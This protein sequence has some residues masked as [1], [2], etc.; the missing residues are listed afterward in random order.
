MGYI[1]ASHVRGKI[2]L[3]DY[4]ALSSLAEST[5]LICLTE[6]D[7]AILLSLLQP[8]AWRRRYFSSSGA[9]IDVAVIESWQISIQERLMAD[10]C[11][12]IIEKLD[13]LTEKVDTANTKLD[14]VLTEITEFRADETT[15]DI[16]KDAALLAIA[17]ELTTL[18]AAVALDSAAI[19]GIALLLSS[20]S[21]EVHDVHIV[22]DEILAA[23]EEIDCSA[24]IYNLSIITNFNDN[25]MIEIVLAALAAQS[26][27]L[28]AK[29]WLDKED[30]LSDTS[31]FAAYCALVTESTR[32]IRSALYRFIYFLDPAE[33]AL[34]ALYTALVDAGGY[35]TGSVFDSAGIPSPPTQADAVA[36]AQ[37]DTAIATVACDLALALATRSLAFA[38]W[39]DA[40]FSLTGYTA[41]SNEELIANLLI[42][43]ATLDILQANYAGFISEYP[44]MYEKAYAAAPTS[45]QDCGCG[46]S[47]C[48]ASATDF[49]VGEKL[50]WI[51][52]RGIY[53]QG[54]GLTATLLNGD[55]ANYGIDISIRNPDLTCQIDSITVTG[56]IQGGGAGGNRAWIEWWH[57]VDGIEV[58]YAE[59]GLSSTGSEQTWDENNPT[60]TTYVSRVRFRTNSTIYGTSAQT[61]TWAIFQSAT[62]TPN[63]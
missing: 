25:L 10:L 4:D 24:P 54:V 1:K 33:S 63:I 38:S 31:A 29:T 16:L 53:R 39:Q 50:P 52:N 60:P 18:S 59:S 30:D 48:D 47:T 51:V 42:G 36:A 6:R 13:T 57:Y 27:A 3:M 17:T 46:L 61:I 34:A 12:E 28:P 14:S 15:D 21:G 40:V 26:A 43:V 58:K 41:D 20:T 2:D 22:V 9:V 62:M 32:W 56:L 44:A 23:V 35:F 8:L 5:C 11:A 55:G 19:A 37:D 7:R 49:T 45:F